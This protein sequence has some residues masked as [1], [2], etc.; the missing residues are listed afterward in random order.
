MRENVAE[1]PDTSIRRRAHKSNIS[2]TTLHRILTKDLPLHTYKIQLT[3][4]LK[5]AGHLKRRVFVNWVHKQRPTNYD[6]SQ[7]ILFSDET[8]FLLGGFVNWQNCRI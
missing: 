8:Y 6:F 4:Q 2:A 7:K 5:P 1:N 3:Q